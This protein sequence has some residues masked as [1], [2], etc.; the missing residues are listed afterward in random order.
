MPSTSATVSQ[1]LDEVVVDVCGVHLG[2]DHL[3]EVQRQQLR[4]ADVQHAV[5]GPEV[6]L[7]R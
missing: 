7:R 4:A 6:G 3:G 5:A 2:P 1:P